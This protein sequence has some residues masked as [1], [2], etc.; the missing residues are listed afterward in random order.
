MRYSFKKILKEILKYKKEFIIANIIA[1]LAVLVSTP[2]PLLMPLLVDE[3]LLKKPGFLTEHIDKLIGHQEA[4]GYILIVLF[5]TLFL[6]TLFYGLTVLHDYLFSIISKNITYKIRKDMLSQIS[7]I[8]LNEYE[9]I[10]SGTISSMFLIDVATIET[11]L[12]MS[13]SKLIVSILTIIGV[14]IV[15]LLINWKLAL[16]ILLVNPFVVVLSKKFA[17]KV[18]YYKKEENKTFESFTE[19]LSETLELF[20]Q[21]RAS[22]QE[23]R[24]I[25]RLFKEALEIKKA[26]IA[27]AYKSDVALR[28]SFLL[29]LGGFEIFRAASIFTVAYGDLTIGLM[30]AIFGY[31]WVMMS[32]VQE[33][34]NIQYSY[35]NAKRA[36]DRINKLFDMEKEPSY[37]HLK[38]PFKDK[39][40]NSVKIEN[41]VFSYDNN[42]DILK[43][44][45]LDIKEG[46]KVAI[47]GAS[48]SGK[49]TLAQIMVG[50]YPLKK[51]ELLIDEINVKEIGLDVL[52]EH[53]YLVLQNP[54]LF[55]DT[56]R[57][58]LTLGK[59]IEDEKIL[60]ALRLAQL[61]DM[62]ESL[63]DGLDTKVGKNGMKLS[64]G[65]RQRISI[66]RM[67]VQNPNVVILD[68]STSALDIHT[69][70]NLFEA[71]KDF[72]KDKTT[73][74]I[75]HRLST[76]RQADYV[77][78]LE[79][80][81]I[82][83]EGT[84]EE[85][86]KKEGSFSNHIK[87]KKD[88]RYH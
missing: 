4:Y 52:R 83:E 64:G 11:F 33:I 37:P 60:E 57:F 14:G 44:I 58:N 7:K 1:I 38:N 35:H 80:G 27:F 40:T 29:F 2:A 48:G 20:R 25:K 88:A 55:N 65:Q 84:F 50:F 63:K 78:M 72:L 34:L 26:G 67:I 22:N 61:G 8:S 49:T 32:P 9:S 73:V 87:G 17:R 36:L 15:L 16:F 71:L 5:M 47:V 43:N 6:R 41:A 23:E 30:L 81:T 59:P 76:I 77:Y 54:L 31:L 19:A 28:F 18:S 53:I 70:E 45:N 21:I 10:G 3:V 13:I 56:I 51:G 79:N 74:I 42:V 62:I 24:F 86:I 69:E 75:A 66:A 82:S 12:G 39:K 68:E 85:L 46:N